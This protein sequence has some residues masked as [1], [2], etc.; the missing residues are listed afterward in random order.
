MYD[1]S[2]YLSFLFD[3]QR[4]KKRGSHSSPIGGNKPLSNP[5]LNNWKFN[6]TEGIVYNVF[7]LLDE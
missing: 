5:F 3:T 2:V 6:Y 1:L 4:S 7:F